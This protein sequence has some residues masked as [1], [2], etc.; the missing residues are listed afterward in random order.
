MLIAYVAEKSDHEAAMELGSK[1]MLKAIYLAKNGQRPPEGAF[2]WR[3]S[4][5]SGSWAS[6]LL[7]QEMERAAKAE[8]QK[9]RIQ[10]LVVSREPCFKCGVRGD[11]GCKH[12]RA[13]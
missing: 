12:R 7:M 13:G 1:M 10:E 9:A 8:A 11:V 6:G 4:A 5:N 3:R 2:H